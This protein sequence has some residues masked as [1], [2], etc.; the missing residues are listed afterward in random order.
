LLREIDF[1]LKQNK[2]FAIVETSYLNKDMCKF[3]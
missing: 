1:L 3:E 2:L